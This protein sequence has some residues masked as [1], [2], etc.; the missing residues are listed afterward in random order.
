MLNKIQE[1][2]ESY[3]PA[4][5]EA[6]LAGDF[7]IIEHGSHTTEIVV[8]DIPMS[9]WNDNAWLYSINQGT[10]HLYHPLNKIYLSTDIIPL[11]AVTSDNEKLAIRAEIAR[12]QEKAK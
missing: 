8:L 4:I 7:E 5:N 10:Y 11:I 6:I 3:V 12:L 9:I 1:I 2:I